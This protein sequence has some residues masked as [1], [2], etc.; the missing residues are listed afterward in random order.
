MSAIAATN[1]GDIVIT[2]VWKH[3]RYNRKLVI[4]FWKVQ[5]P[6]KNRK[7]METEQYSIFDETMRFDPGDKVGEFRLG[8]SIVL[9]GCCCIHSLF[10]GH[11]QSVADLRGARG[12]PVF[13]KGG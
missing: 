11:K 3:K 4:L 9:V 13:H 8:S 1:V 6:V 12:H 7:L 5:E 2:N 10:G